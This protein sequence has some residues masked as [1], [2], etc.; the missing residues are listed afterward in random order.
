MQPCVD[1]VTLFIAKVL[2]EISIVP[3]GDVDCKVN[4]SV[5]VTVPVTV[6]FPLAL[7]KKSYPV[8]AT[9]SCPPNATAAAVSESVTLPFVL[10]T[11]F[12][13]FVEAIVMLPE[14]DK[15]VSAPALMLEPVVA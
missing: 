12:A 3:S 11:R 14:P 13:A 5:A 10:A 15:S 9:D 4:L 7:S 6:I 8:E 2:A 1:T